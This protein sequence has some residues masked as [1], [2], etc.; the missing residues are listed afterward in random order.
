MRKNGLNKTGW[1]E[2]WS[3]FEMRSS[4]LGFEFQQRNFA[5]F[6]KSYKKILN[7]GKKKASH[8]YQQESHWQRARKE[9]NAKMQGTNIFST[10]VFKEET[11]GREEDGQ[12]SQLS[13]R[14]Q[15]A[16]C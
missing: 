8:R 11:Q 6:S 7:I 4:W 1:L 14:L 10:M 9:K 15:E 5:W 16:F 12:K 3:Y 2:I 13:S